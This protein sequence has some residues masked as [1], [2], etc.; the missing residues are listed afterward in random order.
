MYSCIYIYTYDICIIFGLWS[1]YIYIYILCICRIYILDI[2]FSYVFT[3][4]WAW[5][6]GPQH[7]LQAQ[8]VKPGWIEDCPMRV[9]W[10]YLSK[11]T[12]LHPWELTCPLKI[13]GWKMYSLLKIVLFF[14]GHVSFQGCKYPRHPKISP[15]VFSGMFF[16]VQNNL[17][18]GVW[19]CRGTHILLILH[20]LFC[21]CY[22]YYFRVEWTRFFSKR[23]LCSS[24]IQW[25][26]TNGP[27]SK[28][29]SSY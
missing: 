6:A 15:E 29:R 3:C 25:D 4:F 2:L 12:R 7:Q 21:Y 22:Y 10:K 14:R 13:N 26:L 27:V 17:S 9:W 5:Q 1:V 19:M 28:L 11:E 16:R 18:G 8:P 24:K 23:A 20:I